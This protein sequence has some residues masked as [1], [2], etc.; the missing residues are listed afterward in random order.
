VLAE[1]EVN[2]NIRYSQI[3]EILGNKEMTAKEIAHQMYERR[4]IPTDERNFTAPRLT[5]LSI[6][7][8]V[9]PVGKR[10]CLWTNKMV[11]I[12]KRR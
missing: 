8:I 6:K 4:L 7:G 2:K 10:K 12:Y 3:L 11:S 5:E 9:E 1:Q